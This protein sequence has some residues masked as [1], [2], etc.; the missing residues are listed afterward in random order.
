MVSKKEYKKVIK[1][2]DDEIL[3]RQ[4][5]VKDLNYLI[6]KFFDKFTNKKEKND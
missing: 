3:K 2:L 5:I 6:D 1:L 4:G